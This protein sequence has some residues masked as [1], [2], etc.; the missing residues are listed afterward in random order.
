MDGK[1]VIKFSNN[2]ARMLSE[3]KYKSIHGEELKIL[4]ASKI[5]NKTFTSKSR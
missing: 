3:A 5:N 2:L 1:K 4:T